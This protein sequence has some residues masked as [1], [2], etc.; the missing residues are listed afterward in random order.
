MGTQSALA[1]LVAGDGLTLLTSSAGPTHVKQSTVLKTASLVAKT[2]KI[3]L[4][5]SLLTLSW[6][7]TLH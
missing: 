7:H 6:P 1:I 2:E 5:Y 3:V 4:Y